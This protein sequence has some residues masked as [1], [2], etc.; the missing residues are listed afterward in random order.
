MLTNRD[1]GNSRSCRLASRDCLAPKERE[2]RFDGIRR[3][4]L[5]IET[6]IVKVARR[7]VLLDTVPLGTIGNDCS[8]H[9]GRTGEATRAR[10]F[11]FADAGAADY[12]LGAPRAVLPHHA[13]KVSFYGKSEPRV[14]KRPT[15]ART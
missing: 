13:L 10:R 12:R 2:N 7:R 9:V 15:L 3:F 1:S 4:K 14:E 11:S 8:E 5:S 6:V